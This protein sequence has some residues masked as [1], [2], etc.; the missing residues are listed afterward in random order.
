MKPTAPRPKGPLVLS[1][2]L[3]VLTTF[4][5]FLYLN[6]VQA[7]DAQDELVPIVVA[8]KKLNAE[9][10]LGPGDVTV[11]NVPRRLLPPSAFQRPDQVVG[12]LNRF[13]LF[14]H[15]PLFEGK[16]YPKDSE[17][18][19][20]FNIP[21]G[22]RAV[23]VAVDEVIGVAGFIKPGSH[24]DVIG[25]MESDGQK[26][27]KVVLQNIPV[28][29]VAQER[30]DADQRKAKLVTSVTLAV[31][32]QE[33]EVLTLASEKGKIRLALR[34]KLDKKTVSTRG[35]S[36]QAQAKPQAAPP[37]TAPQPVAKQPPAPPKREA[38]PP[39]RPTG[40]EVIRGTQRETAGG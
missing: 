25:A 34:A 5:L 20:S 27:A 32:P 31:S 29:A 39:P 30:E 36:W 13:D 2:S 4:S 37:R 12:R 21:P 9:T 24:V 22:K 16:L 15:D 3:G 10:R 17:G 38:A 28:L 33:S 35:A 40:V 14:P 8:A 11:Q 19:M 7:D 1:V 23:A 18:G 26:S 6:Q